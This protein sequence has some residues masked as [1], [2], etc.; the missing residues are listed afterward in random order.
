MRELKEFQEG[1]F[2]DDQVPATLEFSAPFDSDIP[3]LI[4]LMEEHG[5][6]DFFARAAK[7]ARFRQPPLD[8]ITMKNR[9]VLCLEECFGI[10]PTRNSR[11]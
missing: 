3:Q 11:G 4:A 1:E 5:S 9:W 2:E 7:W 8:G 10:Q 6:S